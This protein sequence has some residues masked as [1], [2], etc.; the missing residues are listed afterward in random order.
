[1]MLLENKVAIVTGAAGGIGT[2]IA[3]KFASEG[4]D[5]VVADLNLQGAN[6]TL[7]KVKKLGRDGLAIQTD[8]TKKAQ[9][10]AMVEKVIGK[11]GRIDIL[12]NNAGTLFDVAATN[13]NS[14]TDIPEDHWDRLLEINLKGC[15][16]CCQAVVPHMKEKRFGKIV[17]FSTLGAI[18]S[19]SIAPHYNAAKAGVLG[20]TYDLAAEMAPYNVNV[21]AILPGPIAT[22]FYGKTVGSAS[23]LEAKFSRMSKAVPL[24][25]MGTPEDVA[26]VVLFFSSELSAFVTGVQLLV[27]GGM[28][29][30]VK[31]LN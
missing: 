2:A 18:H 10:Q 16:L 6:E 17:N 14:I 4:C 26:G 28:P 19:P 24:Q 7:D 15:F 3:T 30:P 23:E 29:L 20:M 12:I 21:N 27:A 11:Y 31:A 1:M 22:A 8:V 13:T 25:R 9:I 5:V